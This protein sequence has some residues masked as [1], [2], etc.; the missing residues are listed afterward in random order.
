MAGIDRNND[1]IAL[2]QSAVCNEAKY[3]RLRLSCYNKLLTISQ[4]PSSSLIAKYVWSG[5]SKRTEE[6]TVQPSI[7]KLCLP[8]S[9]FSKSGEIA[10]LKYTCQANRSLCKQ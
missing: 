9:A 6:V 1:T 10:V 4:L 7:L 8:K 3:W 5:F 2:Y